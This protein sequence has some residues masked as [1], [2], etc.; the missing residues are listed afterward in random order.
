MKRVGAGDY[1]LE[2]GFPSVLQPVR[3]SWNLS[4]L[5]ELSELLLAYL[6]QYSTKGKLVQ[7]RGKR[8]AFYGGW[9]PALALPTAETTRRT[10]KGTCVEL[11]S[12]IRK[13]TQFAFLRIV[14]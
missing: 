12:H 5:A 14:V 13:T 3:R 4:N 9:L 11:L 8:G 1:L 7:R 6:K 10:V 2:I